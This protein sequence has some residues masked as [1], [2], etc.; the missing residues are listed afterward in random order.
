MDIKVATKLLPKW[1]KGL[2][3]QKNNIIDLRLAVKREL[4]DCSLGQNPL[5]PKQVIALQN[6]LL[7][8]ER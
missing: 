3:Y 7:K 6:F 8:T 1:A 5:E 2:A 4:F